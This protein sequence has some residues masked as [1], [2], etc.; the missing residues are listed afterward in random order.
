MKTIFLLLSLLAAGQAT[1]DQSVNGYFRSNG[2]YVQPHQRTSPNSTLFDNYSS[3]G[4][5]N[6]YTGKAGTVNPYK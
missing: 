3:Q 6:P 4:N 2:A 5:Y 1:A